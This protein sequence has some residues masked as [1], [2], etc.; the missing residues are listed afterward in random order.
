MQEVG[1]LIKTYKLARYTFKRNVDCVWANN[2]SVFK[3]SRW[4]FDSENELLKIL[5]LVI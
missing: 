3:V 2:E 1:N 5:R 4:K